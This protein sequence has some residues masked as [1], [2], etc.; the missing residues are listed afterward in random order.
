MRRE[1]TARK[2]TRRGPDDEIDLEFWAR[3]TPNERFAEAW[4][5]SEEIWRLKGWDPGEPGLSRSV[6]R[7]IRRGR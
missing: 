2:I 4:R 5:L 1:I 7:L 6:A 3:V